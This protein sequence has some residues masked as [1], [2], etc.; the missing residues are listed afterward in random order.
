MS[1]S[2]GGSTS[3]EESS[4]ASGTTVSLSSDS[5]SPPYG[6]VAVSR[7]T[8]LARLDMYSVYIFIYIYILFLYSSIYTVYIYIY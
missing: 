1:S 8:L 5:L 3:I 2:D 6:F 7:K 4:P